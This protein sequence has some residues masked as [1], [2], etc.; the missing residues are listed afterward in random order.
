MRFDWLSLIF[1]G[2]E[3]QKI[4][5]GPMQTTKNT[6]GGFAENSNTGGVPNNFEYGGEVAEI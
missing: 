2:A 3:K 4:Y 1:S 5:T 6:G